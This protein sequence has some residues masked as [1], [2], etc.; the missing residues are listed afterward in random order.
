[1]FAIFVAITLVVTYWA[2]GQSTTSRGFYAADRKIGGLQNGW[3]IAGDYVSAATFLGITGLVAFYGFDGFM[4]SVGWLVGYLAVLLFVAEPLRNAGKYTLADLVSLRLRGRGVRATVALS[5]LAITLIYLIAQMVGVSALVNLLIPRLGEVVPIVFVGV[6]MLIYV[7]FGGMLAT[8]W[9]QIIKAVLLLVST[10][11]LCVL[12]LGQFH[13]SIGTFLDAAAN[14]GV[15]GRT[16]NLLQPGLLFNGPL[17]GWNLVSLGLALVLGTAGLPHIL[18][19]FFTVPSAQAAR[20]SVAW[21]ML[22]IG[23]FYLATAFMG[24]GAATLVGREHIGER[25]YA[26]Q[27]IA[28][29]AAHPEQA[30]R[31]NRQLARQ[32]YI[33]PQEDSNLAAPLLA[34]KLGG[35]LLTAFV[36]AVAFATI[37]AVVAGLT[38]TASSAVAHDFWFSLIRNGRGTESEHLFVARSTAFAVGAVA[39]GLAIALRTY[40]VAFLV[41]LAFA[42]AAS[43]N[44]PVIVLALAWRRFSR[45][46]AISGILGGLISSFALIALSPVA[47]GSNA[48]FP[49]ENPGIVSIPIGF[50][51]AIAGTLLF[52]DRESEE[53]FDQLQVR[54]T[55]GLGAEV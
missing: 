52:R 51:A 36:A 53:T 12:I 27:A 44:V 11:G 29:I 40:N 10:L 47:M 42:V 31:L 26:G 38:I 7:I 13:F 32:D 25:M 6:L 33:V 18:M 43:A 9:V 5:T 54:A 24:L 28:Y 37:L 45:A 34:A 3:A 41:G 17:G 39:I 22:L 4:Y 21:A 50:I 2:S 15:G 48:I 23:V 55:T 30:P 19:R 35:S 49:L 46:G 14:V 20:A 8:T 1:M 16:M